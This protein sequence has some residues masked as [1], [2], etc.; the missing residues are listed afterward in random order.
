M[1]ECPSDTYTSGDNCEDCSAADFCAECSYAP[2]NCTA[3]SGG[4]FLENPDYGTC[5]DTCS[6]ANSLY[7]VV[8]YKCVSTCADNLVYYSPL[9]GWGGLNGCDMCAN[10]TY[11]LIDDQACHADCPATYY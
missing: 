4:K 11:K 6:G 5:I 7:D 8:N 10:G 2:D 1:S 3:C 9:V